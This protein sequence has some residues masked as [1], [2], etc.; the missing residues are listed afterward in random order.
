M[1]YLH[2]NDTTANGQPHEC[3]RVHVNARIRQLSHGR[4]HAVIEFVF[5]P[6]LINVFVNAIVSESCS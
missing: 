3:V 2:R 1:C 5:M 4:V 6:M